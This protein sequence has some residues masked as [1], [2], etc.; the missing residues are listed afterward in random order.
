MGHALAVVCGSGLQS[1]PGWLLSRMV[2][3]REDVSQKD[4][5]QMVTLPE[6]RFLGGHFPG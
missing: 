4:D 2:F 3:S 6:R 1:F 5:S